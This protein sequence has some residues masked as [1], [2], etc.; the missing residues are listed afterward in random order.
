LTILLSA[1]KITTKFSGGDSRPLK[2]FVIFLGLTSL[3][4]SFLGSRSIL[5]YNSASSSLESQFGMYQILIRSKFA[6]KLLTI[7]LFAKK[8]TLSSAAAIAVR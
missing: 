7:L 6:R 2:R 3:F 8:I 4:P 1:K 5:F